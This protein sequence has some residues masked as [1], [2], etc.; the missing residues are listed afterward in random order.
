[1]N[2]EKMALEGFYKAEKKEVQ[3]I[4]N[5]IGKELTREILRSHD[6][7]DKTIGR[8]RNVSIALRHLL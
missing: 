7:D 1:V 3:Q 8:D 6:I 4:V 2:F 5:N